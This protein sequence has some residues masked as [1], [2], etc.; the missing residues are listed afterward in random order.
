[1]REAALSKPA[2]PAGAECAAFYP[3]LIAAV[4]HRIAEPAQAIDGYWRQS[5]CARPI[6]AAA[7]VRRRHPVGGDAGP[8]LRQG[9]TL[10]LVGEMARQVALARCVVR[11]VQPDAGAIRFH[12]T[13]LAAR[14]AGVEAV[15]TAFRYVRTV[16]C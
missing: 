1:M 10:G 14:P 8:V 5:A 3:A 7:A 12:D 4:P 11:L 16:H 13:D 2:Q 15:Q 9:E 6:A